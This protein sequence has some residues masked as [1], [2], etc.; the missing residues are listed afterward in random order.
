MVVPSYFCEKN[1]LDSFGIVKHCNGTSPQKNRSSYIIIEW[2]LKVKLATCGQMQQ[3][4][5]EQAERRKSQKRKS[6]KKENAGARKC[7][8]VAIHCVFPMFWGSG[9]SESRLAKAG[10]AEPSRGMK[11]ENYK[12]TSSSEH[13]KFRRANS[14][15]RCGAKHTSKWKCYELLRFGSLWE[16]RSTVLGQNA[17]APH[18]RTVFWGRSVVLR[19]RDRVEFASCQEC[20]RCVGFA[21]VS[22]R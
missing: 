21:A 3:Q 17:K 18:V 13:F 11:D 4:W 19:S 12:D 2:N 6:Q 15:R 8:K 9:G 7:R 1:P 14:A 10:G 22:T 5:W 16:V 20:V